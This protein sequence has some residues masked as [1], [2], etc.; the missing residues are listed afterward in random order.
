MSASPITKPEMSS[1]IANSSLAFMEWKCRHSPLLLSAEFAAYWLFAYAVS[2]VGE[3]NSPALMASLI[4]LAPAGYRLHRI[5]RKT[6]AI[7]LGAGKTAHQVWQ[8]KEATEN[9]AKIQIAG[10]VQVAEDEISVPAEF[11]LGESDLQELLQSSKS[12]TI[13]IAPDGKVPAQIMQQLLDCKLR[14]TNIVCISSLTS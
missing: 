10:F 14:G 5:S 12:D 4:A 2:F 1:E 6:R 11:V 3:F 7:V 8:D 9:K 13:V